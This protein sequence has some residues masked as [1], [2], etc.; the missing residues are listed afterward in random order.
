MVKVLNPI[1][2]VLLVDD[3][4]AWLNSFG[5]SLQVSGINNVVTCND[6]RKVMD[7]LE[8]Q[9][10]SVLV[11]DLTMPHLAGDELLP[12]VVQDFPEIPVS[13]SYDPSS[14]LMNYTNFI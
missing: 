3:E 12:Q 9:E 7:L 4:N 5:L 6:S 14:L 11:L 10:I 2:P 13:H 1:L 8:K